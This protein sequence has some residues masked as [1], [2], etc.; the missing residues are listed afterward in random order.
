MPEGRS[1]VL[2]ARG[3]GSRGALHE[4]IGWEKAR[5]GTHEAFDGVNWAPSVKAI[6]GDEIHR[7]RT[8]GH[9]QQ[10]A[11]ILAAKRQGI[12]CSC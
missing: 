8:K 1:D 12:H 10:Y 11:L 7:A 3:G 5:A 9:P 2:E 6:I 4:T